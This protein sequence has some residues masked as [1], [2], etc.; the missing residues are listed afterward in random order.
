M[1]LTPLYSKPVFAGGIHDQVLTRLDRFL[2]KLPLQGLGRI[3]GQPK[4]IEVNRCD[5]G[6]VYFNPIRE[7]PVFI[8]NGRTIAGHYFVENQRLAA[9]TTSPKNY[10]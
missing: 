5:S 6:I 10:H 4:S 2:R 8:R 9:K 1:K 3:I 7:I